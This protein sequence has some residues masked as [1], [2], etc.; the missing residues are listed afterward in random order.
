MKLVTSK[1][2]PI[3]HFRHQMRGPR[4]IV[5][6]PQQ[7][8]SRDWT[9]SQ[10]VVLEL[11]RHQAGSGMDPVIIST[12]ALSEIRHEI[13]DSIRVHRHPHSYLFFGSGDGGIR[14]QHDTGDNLLSIPVFQSLMQE[15]EVRLFHAQPRMTQ[16]LDRQAIAR[17]V[18]F[19]RSGIADASRASHT[20]DC[21]R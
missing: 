9:G 18:T 20:R 10:A 4:R 11:A 19:I 5:H 21:S 7:F 16:R 13:I 17:V 15:P 1:A 8:A 12:L 2:N 14:A 6:V 3:W